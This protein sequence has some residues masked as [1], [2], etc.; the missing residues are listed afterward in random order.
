MGCSSAAF[1]LKRNEI[2]SEKLTM[3]LVELTTLIQCSTTGSKEC[4]IIALR[5]FIMQSD[6]PLARFTEISST[7]LWDN[8]IRQSRHGHLRCD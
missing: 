7:K 8:C 3:A 1:Q 5:C 6:V 4:V 2:Y